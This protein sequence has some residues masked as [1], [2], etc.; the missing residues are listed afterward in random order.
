[1]E[2]KQAIEDPASPAHGAADVDRWDDPPEPDAVNPFTDNPPTAHWPRDPLGR[3]RAPIEEG[4]QLVRAAMAEL[5]AHPDTPDDED[6]PD[7]W[8]ADVE[9]LLAEHHSATGVA[10]E[11]ELPSRLPATALVELRADPARLAARLRRPLPYPPNPLAR[12]GTAFHAWVQRWFAAEGLLGLDELPGAA[13][14]A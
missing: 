14:T 2:L 1:L 12:R 3:R 8:A 6:D 13:D 4:A 5:T 9:A 10:E 7:G 11:V